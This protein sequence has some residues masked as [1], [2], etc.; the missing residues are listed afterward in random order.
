M[1]DAPRRD[2]ATSEPE[3]ERPVTA[4]PDE[5]RSGRDP[6][7]IDAWPDAEEEARAMP[8][9][10]AADHVEEDRHEDAES[11]DGP[12]GEEPGA[13]PDPAEDPR[14]REELLAALA[15]TEQQR[16]D[17]L[18][19]MQRARAEFD[20]Y[21]R[22]TMREGAS[23]REAGKA[24]V[25][26]G[27][28]EV[29]DDLDRTLEAADASAD[30][31]L[32]RGVHLVAEKLVTALRAAGLERIDETGVAFDP[33]RHEAVQQA[34][35]DEPREDPVVAQVLRPGYALGDRVLRAAMVVV[36]Q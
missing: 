33:T 11:S 10:P 8:A 32:A 24:E 3:E 9:E 26:E 14:S 21:R 18:D 36:E 2:P 1:S 17:Y 6:D 22:R 30:D 20:N 16:D 15:E 13:G 5:Q 34:A 7:A 4:V 27:L 23:Q 19:G 35:A 31:G 25:S 12:G 28:L 29:L